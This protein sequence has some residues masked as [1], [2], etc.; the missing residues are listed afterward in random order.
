MFGGANPLQFQNSVAK[1][2]GPMPPLPPGP[3]FNPHH[4]PHPFM[5][6]LFPNHGIDPS[7]M[8]SFIFNQAAAVAALQNQPPMPT[9]TSQ[10]V[11][12]IFLLKLE[13]LYLS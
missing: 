3:P 2:G 5:H 6:N 7:K 12:I 9:P 8:M 13:V 1:V 11:I 10:D 4:H